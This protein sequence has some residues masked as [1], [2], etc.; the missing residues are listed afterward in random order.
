MKNIKNW[1]L[2]FSLFAVFEVCVGQGTMEDALYA[3]LI[4]KLQIGVMTIF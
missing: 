3:S 2:C 4:S 1:A